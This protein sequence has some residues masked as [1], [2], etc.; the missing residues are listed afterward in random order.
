MSIL[1]VGEAYGVEE[2][3]LDTPFVGKC[4]KYLRNFI[5]RLDLKCDIDYTNICNYRPKSATG[6]TR[7]PTPQEMVT[8]RDH[9]FCL[10]ES[11]RP[12]LIIGLGQ[13]AM[14]GMFKGGKI[15]E[16]RKIVKVL[17]R[18]MY[19]GFTYHPSY[20]LRFNKKEEL[21]SDIISYISYI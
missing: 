8:G 13:V 6:Q 19:L 7:K 2:E 12:S 21:E 17:G 3:R 11:T 14:H 4:G 1:I 9:L 16:N 10:I 18:P 20:A 5:N 15:S